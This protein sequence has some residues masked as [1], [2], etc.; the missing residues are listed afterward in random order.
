M[1]PPTLEDV[2]GIIACASILFSFGFGIG[3]GVAWLFLC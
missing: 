1:Y 2:S 3:F